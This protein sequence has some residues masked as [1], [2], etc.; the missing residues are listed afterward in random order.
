[1]AFKNHTGN[2]HHMR[3]KDGGRIAIRIKTL[4]KHENHGINEVINT[5]QARQNDVCPWTG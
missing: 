3:K 5:L 4:G 1:M 2:E